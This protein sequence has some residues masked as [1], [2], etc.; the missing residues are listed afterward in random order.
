MNTTNQELV[1]LFK[2]LGINIEESQAMEDSFY[3]SRQEL[4]KVLDC[5][6]TKAF[7]KDLDEQLK[8]LVFNLDLIDSKYR[9]A[10]ILLLK[11]IVY[12]ILSSQQFFDPNGKVYD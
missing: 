8:T 6:K 2:Q 4:L 10:D 5:V 9:S 11:K 12:H 1:A 7:F 3:L